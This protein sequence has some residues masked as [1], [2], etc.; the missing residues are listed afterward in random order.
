MGQGRRPSKF[1]ISQPSLFSNLSDLA[2]DYYCPS[3]LFSAY[4]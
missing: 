3:G 4:L 1:A 2:I